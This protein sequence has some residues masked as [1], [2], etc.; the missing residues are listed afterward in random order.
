MQKISA[1]QCTLGGSVRFDG[2]G[3][4]SANPVKLVID[5]APANTGF[6]IARILDDNSVVG[7]VPVD[8]SCVTRTTLCTTVDLGNS[9][10][11]ATVEHV[12]SA[13]SG[14]GIDNA[15]LTLDGPECPI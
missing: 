13:L 11:V 7:P 6:Q 1:R 2:I 14:L 8:Y 9:V 4:H 15:I 5:P 10:S 12:I 3:V